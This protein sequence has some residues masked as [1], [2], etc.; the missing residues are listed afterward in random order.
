MLLNNNSPAHL[1]HVVSSRL[2]MIVLSGLN[3]FFYIQRMKYDIIT[4]SKHI[5]QQMK[6]FSMK[7]KW[8][9]WK[10]GATEL[11]RH[12]TVFAMTFIPSFKWII[13]RNQRFSVR[14]ASV[15][16]NKFQSVSQL[17]VNDH[18]K[19]SWN[20]SHINYSSCLDAS[21]DALA[22]KYLV[23]TLVLTH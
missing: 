23:L 11:R 16:I 19:F 8:M 21:A 12:G 7:Y 13:T 10:T 14:R 9:R 6:Y 15:F 1:L 2:K 20:P 17:S 18:S 3:I 4:F 22:L 5:W